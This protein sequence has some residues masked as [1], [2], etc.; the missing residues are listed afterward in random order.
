MP[1][2]LKDFTQLLDEYQPPADL[3]AG[4]GL[5]DFTSLLD[6]FE[7]A[8]PPA[9]VPPPKVIPQYQGPDPRSAKGMMKDTVEAFYEVGRYPME[10]YRGLADFALSLPAFAAALPAAVGTFGKTLIDQAAHAK[11]EDFFVEKY[12]DLPGIP[13]EKL[14]KASRFLR[15]IDKSAKGV[16]LLGPFNLMEAYNA[17]AESLKEVYGLF[18]PGQ[19]KL[20]GEP[21]EQSQRVG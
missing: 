2:G 14:E 15:R 20:V 9:P 16:S 4:G 7:A 19:R 8:Q 1:E 6:E 21:T 17:A 12:P 18:E 11:W 5:K 10:T 13:A 3:S